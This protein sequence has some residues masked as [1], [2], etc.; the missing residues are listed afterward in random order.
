MFWSS[1]KWSKNRNPVVVNVDIF[2]APARLYYQI[3]TVVSHYFMLVTFFCNIFP[4]VTEEEKAA[5]KIQ[6]GFRGMKARKELKKKKQKPPPNEGNMMLLS[7]FCN[8]E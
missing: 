6:A 4:Y 8:D 2:L 7:I 1:N 5:I 3:S